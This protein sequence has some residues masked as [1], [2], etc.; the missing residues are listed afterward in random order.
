ME[1]TVIICTYNRAADLE[2]TLSS[3]TAQETPPG[4]EWELLVVDN[5]SKDNTAEIAKSFAGRLPLVYLHEPRQGKGNALETAIATARAPL[6]IFT[7]DDV[8][9]HPGWV[10]AYVAAARK[11]PDA[12]FF[13]G[14]VH[15]S[16]D[17]RPPQ[18]YLDNEYWLR[19]N[20]RIDLGEEERVYSEPGSARFI[21]ANLAARRVIQ[22]E[23]TAF[24]TELG[25]RGHYG[26]AGARKQAEEFELQN[27]LM[28]RGCQG[29]Y[30][31][32]AII[33]HRDPPHRVT[34]EY[35]IYFYTEQ[36]REEVLLEP[37]R[38]PATARRLFGAPLYLWKQLALGKVRYLQGRL[39][40]KS[41]TWL[42]G[43]VQAASCWG[44]I[45]AYRSVAAGG[46]AND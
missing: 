30:V 42:R 41:G 33:Y 2:K 11:H 24:R 13:G 45:L 23:L 10:A 31:P 21:G 17:L 39:T 12:D 37:D 46:R 43:A 32:G 16:K 26:Q 38:I 34:L 35:L 28:S 36:G 6:L 20:P 8:D 1:A 7:D 4:L 3:L 19:A 15:G 5:N 27:R 44:Q 29:R 40:G 14:A 22:G 9:V 18:W 25:P